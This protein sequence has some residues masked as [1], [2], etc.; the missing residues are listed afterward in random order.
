MGAIL[1]DLNFD[2]LHTHGYRPDVVLCGLA[3]SRGRAHVTT[4]HGFVGGSMRARFYEWAQVQAAKYANGV[5][6]VS[7]QIAD[8]LDVSGIS[9]NARTIRNAVAADNG[10]LE[11][12]AARSQLGLPSDVNLVGWIGR[13]SYEKGPDLFVKALAEV[14]SS[15]H[16][17]MIGDGPEMEN[18]K[19]L[20]RAYG[21]ADRLRLP[22]ILPDARRFL[23]AFDCLVLS[24]RTEGTPMVLLECMWAGVPIVTAAVGGIPDI[25]SPRE[26]LVCPPNAT[27]PLSTAI[28]TV[29]ANAAD[30]KVRATAAL[31]RVASEHSIE[32]W[33]DQHVR[34]YTE[35]AQRSSTADRSGS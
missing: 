9:T 2:I 15:L 20:A 30:A 31:E 26:A 1:D 33:I 32:S 11:R 16:A 25:L 3:R 12:E 6:A 21:I 17:V 35:V 7:R 4:F 14:D 10:L 34:L 8:R 23:K 27:P 24:S 5:V 13:L 18:V 29:F 22:G 28:N 19:A